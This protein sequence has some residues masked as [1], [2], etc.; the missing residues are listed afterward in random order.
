MPR[1]CKAAALRVFIWDPW[2]FGC[3]V[4]L[5][6]ALDTYRVHFPGTYVL[7]CF[8]NLK[9][10]RGPKGGGAATRQAELWGD[11]VGRCGRQHA[12]TAGAY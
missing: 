5:P 6:F 7:D 2:R 8:G 9:G 4:K 3:E 12:P 1:A 10:V 11:E